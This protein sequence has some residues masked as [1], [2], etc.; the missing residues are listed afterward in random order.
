M[1]QPVILPLLLFPPQDFPIFPMRVTKD[2]KLTTLH[3]TLPF[4]PSST[5]ASFSTWSPHLSSIC[6]P[7]RFLPT[8]FRG[9]KKMGSPE[10]IKL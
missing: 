9:R 6:T 4:V 2:I 8:F 3:P 7:P 5:P 10:I 1:L